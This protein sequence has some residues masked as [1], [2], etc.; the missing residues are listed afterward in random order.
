MWVVASPDLVQIDPDA[1][2]VVACVPVIRGGRAE[3]ALL[4]G[5]AT[6]NGEAWVANPENDEIAVVQAR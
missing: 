1:G 5:L 3:S 4:N 6:A 2:R